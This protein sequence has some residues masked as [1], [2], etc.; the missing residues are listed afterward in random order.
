[1]VGGE[2]QTKI[3]LNHM[4]VTEEWMNLFP[5]VRVRHMAMSISD[6]CLLMLT[7]KCKQPQ[8]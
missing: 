2:Q 8:K 6:K 5:K 1:M 7:L 4:V 3:R